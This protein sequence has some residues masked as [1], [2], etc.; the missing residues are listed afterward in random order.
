MTSRDITCVG[1]ALYPGVAYRG[2]P[3]WKAWLA[4]GLGVHRPRVREWTDGRAEISD[5]AARVLAAATPL[6]QV[7]ALA[8]HP[9]GTPIAWRI[10]EL[11]VAN[12]GVALPVFEDGPMA[13]EELRR[14]GLR[15][16]PGMDDHPVRPRWRAALAGGLGVERKRIHVWE[17]GGSRV[18]ALATR[19]LRAAAPFAEHLGLA[20][21]PRGTSIVGRL[22]DLAGG[23][24]S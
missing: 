19:I 5:M 9:Q 11:A 16:L 23:R 7:L 13:P 10:A 17:H 8:D 18:P 1:Q 14:I 21:L 4:D 12:L 22:A 6:A 2:H 20:G 3:A 24:D 15:L